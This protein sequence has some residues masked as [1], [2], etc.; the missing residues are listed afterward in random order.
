MTK[1]YF[2]F[3]TNGNKYSTI[4]ILK[5]MRDEC[6]R[7][8]AFYP[9]ICDIEASLTHFTDSKTGD[10]T[11]DFALSASDSE[12]WSRFDDEML[13]LS[14][15]YPETM[16]YLYGRSEEN[17][18]WCSRYKNGRTQYAPANITYEFEDFENNELEIHTN[19]TKEHLQKAQQVLVDS[20]IEADET[21]TVLQ[22]LGYVLLDKELESL[23]DWDFEN[24]QER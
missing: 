5:Y 14:E 13:K 10:V 15:V 4:E 20:G 24:R 17:E 21:G 1:N 18:L 8:L 23:I 11:T 9:F 2:S 16:F 7:K 6:N 22:A 19:I 12:H 3:S